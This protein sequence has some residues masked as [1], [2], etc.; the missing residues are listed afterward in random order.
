MQCTVDGS[1]HVFPDALAVAIRMV[2]YSRRRHSCCCTVNNRLLSSRTAVNVQRQLGLYA[3][4]LFVKMLVS[5]RR[6]VDKQICALHCRAAQK[7]NTPLANFHPRWSCVVMQM[8]HMS[9]V[10][11]GNRRNLQELVV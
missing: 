6:A 11:A 1:L 4:S 7:T 2:V 9:V 5:I 10:S 8:L 3:H